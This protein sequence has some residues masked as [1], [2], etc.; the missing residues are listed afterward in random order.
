MEATEGSGRSK[1]TRKGDQR[2]RVALLR[3]VG[4]EKRDQ[5]GA[6]EEGIVGA[7][8]G[9]VELNTGQGIV[10]ALAYRKG[11]DAQRERRKWRESNKGS[12]G[13]EG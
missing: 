10:D 9:Q 12:M 11:G 8:E 7:T 6:E 5:D 3:A 1:G 4:D 2:E 13:I